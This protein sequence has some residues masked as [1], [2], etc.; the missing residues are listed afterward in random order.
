MHTHIHVT[1]LIT[2]K[3]ATNLRKSRRDMRGV[4][5]MRRKGERCYYVLNKNLNKL[6]EP[7]SQAYWSMS[8]IL[9]RGEGVEAGSAVGGS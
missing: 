9:A 5:G 1:M 4:L 3:H 7:K 2:E 8:A 6:T